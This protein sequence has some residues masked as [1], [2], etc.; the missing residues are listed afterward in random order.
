MSRSAFVLSLS[1]AACGPARPQ[2]LDTSFDIESGR[3]ACADGTLCSPHAVDRTPFRAQGSFAEAPS[4]VVRANSCDWERDLT[5]AEAFY[6]VRVWLPGLLEVT[7]ETDEDAG[8]YVFDRQ[9][10]DAC[11]GGGDG[12]QLI[13]GYIYKNPSCFYSF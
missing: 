6:E 9:D 4:A 7:L 1:L 13:S 5:G 12:R 10:G 11:V 2:Q 8:V 3:F